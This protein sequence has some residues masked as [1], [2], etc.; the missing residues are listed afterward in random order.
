MILSRRV[1]LDGAQLDEIDS[2]VVIQSVKTGAGKNTITAVSLYGRD[3]QRVT[4][5]QRDTI[6]VE[7]EFG[8]LIRKE[9]MAARAE[10]LE[11]VNAWAAAASIENGGAWLT[12]EH[13]ANR[14]MRVV[15][16]EPA[17]EGDLRE[18]AR[19]FRITFRAYGVPYWQE[20]EPTARIS[21]EASTSW[22]GT[23]TVGGNARTAAD[24]SLTNVSGALLNTAAISVGGG[25]MWFEG[26]GLAA[27]ETLVID[28][29]ETGT[30]RIRIRSAGGV[31]RSAL[32]KRTGMSADDFRVMPGSAA[33]SYSTQRA[34]S[35]TAS[36]PGRF[37]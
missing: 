12:L 20:A 31:Y 22:S 37:L 29:D 7:I 11:A 28:H 6:D 9:E 17:D 30:I 24:V 27:D 23:M 15:L 34:C 3:G 16:A 33:V 4:G 13:K 26:L 21:G 18:W 10:L 2:R 14:R 35:V 5:A 19:N 36:A 8:L 25:T 1:A 32:G